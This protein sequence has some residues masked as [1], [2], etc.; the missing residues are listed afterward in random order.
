MNPRRLIKILGG[1]ATLL[2]FLGLVIADTVD[3]G[4]TLSFEDKVFLL[5]LIGSLLGVDK[6][7]EKVP[8]LSIG[9]NNGGKDD[10]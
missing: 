10:E 5:T 4:V 9:V 7:L 3:A 2:V 1:L 8:D 6:L